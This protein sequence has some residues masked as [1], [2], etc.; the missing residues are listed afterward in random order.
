LVYQIDNN[1]PG[2]IIADPL[3]LRQ[4]LINLVSN[5]MKFT[6]KGEVFIS[7]KLIKQG[8]E[9]LMLQFSVRDTG[10][11][12]PADKLDKLFKAFSQVDSS[13][14]R[15]YG[16]TGLGL[17]ISEKL[18]KLMGGEITVESET[19]IGTTFSFTIKS[20]AGL[21]AQRN[22]VYLNM[23]ELIGKRILIVDDNETNRNILK[24]QLEQWNFEPIIADSGENALNLISSEKKIDLIISDMN[25][26]VMDGI[27]LAKE[28]RKKQSDLPIILLSS[29]GNEQ[30]KKES[31][32]FNAILNKPA[33][34]H[35]L[36]KHIAEVLK[37]NGTV[38]KETQPI[39]SQFSIEFAVQY[40]MNILIAEDNL[41]NQKLA[42]HIFTKMGYAPDMAENGHVAINAMINKRYDIIFMDVQMPEMDGLETTRF[43][44][45]HMEYQPTIV[46]MTANAL[47]EDRELCLK[48]GMDDYLS[49]PMKITSIMDVLEKWGK[50]INN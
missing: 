32:L 1:V 4:V 16:G 39:Q 48:V 40:P 26:P 2:Q 35:I 24:T 12:I 46:A 20:K 25:M 30:S 27:Q 34:H 19:G 22:Y 10:I 8:D 47:P 15:K 3:R 36:Y 50:R 33:R 42:R 6:S 14:T 43:I 37:A 45:D 21:K 7:V 9:E 5:A 31:H 28:I 23:A 44:R 41:V 29:M 17:A 18:V 38:I 13:T 11:G 49:K